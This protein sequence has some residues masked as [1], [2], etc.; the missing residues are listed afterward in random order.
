MDKNDNIKCELPQDID[1]PEYTLEWFNSWATRAK[2]E[3]WTKE[4]IYYLVDTALV[5][6]AVWGDLDMSALGELHKRE[7]FMGLNFNAADNVTTVKK[8]NIT[9]LEVIQNRRNKKASVS[10]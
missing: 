1:W 4:Q 10:A 7:Q 5:H 9:P 6:A 3:K 2:N 8:S